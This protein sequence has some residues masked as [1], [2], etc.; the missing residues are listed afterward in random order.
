MRILGVDPGSET[1]GYGVIE[2]DGHKHRLVESGAI[3]PPR[4]RPFAQKLLHIAEHLQDVLDR[5]H[6]EAVALEEAFA[7]VN[8]K[9]ALKLGHVRGVVLLLA[10]RAGVPVYE[11]SPLE[12]KSATVGYGRAEKPQVQR[13]VALLLDLPEPPEPHDVADALA[14]AICHAHHLGLLWR[15]SKSRRTSS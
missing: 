12:V 8:P 5:R 6:P 15:S 14:V 2:T 9:S 11:Y 1:T 13:M 3:R 4:N 10:A 7:A